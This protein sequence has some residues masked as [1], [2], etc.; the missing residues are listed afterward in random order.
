M[1][2]TSSTPCP[3]AH[4]SQT[5]SATANSHRRRQVLI[6]TIIAVTGAIGTIHSYHER[7]YNPEPYHTSTLSGEEWVKEL[8]KGHPECMRNNLGVG[9]RVFKKLKSELRKEGNLKPCRHVG[10]SEMLV[11][12]L[13]QAVTNLSV[14]KVAERFQQSLETISWYGL[15]FLNV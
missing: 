14:R 13:Y 15:L 11:T 2:R 5:T 12:F 1:V 3:A 10:I 9:R 7:Q 6:T 4:P 8:H